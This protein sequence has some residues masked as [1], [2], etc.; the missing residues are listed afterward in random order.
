MIRLLL[1]MSI[2]F[3]S[4]WGISL[5]ILPNDPVLLEKY[6]N[7]QAQTI[8]LSTH[9]AEPFIISKKD[10]D[11][12]IGKRIY[13]VD[14]VYTAFRESPDFDQVSL[15]EN[16]MAELEKLLPQ[17]ADDHPEWSFYKQ[18]G[19]NDKAT[20][21]TYFHGFVIHY[22]DEIDYQSMNHYFEKI[23]VPFSTIDIDNRTGGRAEY[24]SGSSIE[25]PAL[26][27]IHQNGEIVEGI[28]Q[29]YYREFRD[30]AEIALSGIPMT[31]TENGNDE[32]FNSA[33]MYEIRAMQNGEELKLQQAAIVNF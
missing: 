9:F 14:L 30:Q 24:Y 32:I 29:L 12:L 3:V 26:A 19:A 13:H 15:N 25:M 21:K 4:L 33:G 17:L 7:T 6:T 28:Y 18:T 16:R 22:G 8:E 20:A 27:A 31:Y 11:Q 1:S 23:Q 2:S 10:I 5:P